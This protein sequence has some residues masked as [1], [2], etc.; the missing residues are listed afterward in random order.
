[1]TP[2][3]TS[4][5]PS[6]T[7]ISAL[8]L[9]RANQALTDLD[10]ARVS[11]TQLQTQ[12]ASTS[13]ALSSAQAQLDAA[14]HP[15]APPPPVVVVPP[16]VVTPPPPPVTTAPGLGLAVAGRN[17]TNHAGAAVGV[18]GIELMAGDQTMSD[19]V[20]S[21]AACKSFGANAV[22]PLFRTLDTTRVRAY[23]DAALAAKVVCAVNGDHLEQA[24][25]TTGATWFRRPDVAA[26][27]NSY[28]NVI[29][30][31]EVEIDNAAGQPAITW[32][33]WRDRVNARVADL[34]AA[35]HRSPIKVGSPFSGR[36]PRHAIA[37]G[38]EVL[39]ADPLHSVI[40]TAQMYYGINPASTWTYTEE[41]GFSNPTTK[42]PIAG[43]KQI[44]DALVASGLCFI[45]GLDAVD[46]IGATGYE[47]LAA[48]LHSKGVGWWF[49]AMCNDSRGS[50]VADGALSTTPASPY[51]AAVKALLS[52][53]TTALGALSF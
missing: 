5:L 10:T 30:E 27:L 19:V 47:A 34:R 51:G 31:D 4:V 21:I 11:I 41:F 45:V 15:P 13:A 37:H 12:L 48:Y 42:D 43:H 9:A 36:D 18:R 44:V 29:V 33:Q 3:T 49:W 16:P 40:F 1:M 24:T 7:T 38:A 50:N 52:G 6:V 17:V 23:L 25:G 20:R 22:G 8:E 39:A 46:D 28:P 35:G 14:L 26:L 53:Q 2:I 32:Q